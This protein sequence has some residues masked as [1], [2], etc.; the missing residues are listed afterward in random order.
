MTA[1]GFSPL[2]NQDFF[3]LSAS[4][5]GVEFRSDEEHF[6][7]WDE[8]ALTN[9]LQFFSQWCDQNGSSGREREFIQ[10]Y[11]YEQPTLL[12]GDRRSDFYR[13]SFFQALD[14]A[15]FSIPAQKKEALDFFWLSKGGKI[16]ASG[17]IMAFGVPRGSSNRAGANEFLKWIF[18]PATQSRIL[19]EIS[20]KNPHSFGIDGG[21]SSLVAI[22]EEQ[23]PKYEPRPL[24]R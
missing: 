21:F 8:A 23:L 24:F 14:H 15:F 22:N 4:L 9:C 20:V 17:K 13:I 11:L 6:L 7:T 5:F 16:P 2:W 18:F 12:I 10:K 1:L 3:F 19:E